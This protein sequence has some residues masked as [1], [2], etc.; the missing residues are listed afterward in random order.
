VRVLEWRAAAAGQRRP[1]SQTLA[2]WYEPLAARAGEPCEDLRRLLRLVEWALYCEGDDRAAPISPEQFSA[3]AHRVARHWTA[4]RIRRLAA[5]GAV[6]DWS[7][8]AA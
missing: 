5:K 2:A 8:N 4:S 3:V 1:K 7:T 6:I